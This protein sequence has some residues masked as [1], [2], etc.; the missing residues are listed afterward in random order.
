[1]RTLLAWLLLICFALAA[2]AQSG[3][4]DYVMG[5]DDVLDITVRNHSE[6][7]KTV[8]ILLDGKIAFGEVGEFVAAGKTPRALAQEI[9]TELEKTRNKVMVTVSVKEVHSRRVRILGAVRTPGAYDLKRNW[10]LMDVVAVAGG[11]TAKPTRINGRI[12]HANN[13][14]QLVDAAAAVAK[15]D[16]DANPALEVD[17]LIMLDEQEVVK[18]TINILGQVGKPGTY[19]LTENTTLL[20]IIADANGVQPNAALS[21]AYVLRGTTRIPMNMSKILLKSEPDPTVTGFKLQP[22]DLI[23]I[24]E[25][26]QRIAI[27]GSVL[28]PGY[29]G[30]ADREKVTLMDALGIAGGQSADANMRGAFI[31]HP[32]DGTPPTPAN[33][34]DLLKKGKGREIVLKAGDVLYV[35]PRGTNRA[36]NVLDFINPFALL[37]NVFGR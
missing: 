20:T 5:A 21:K 17:D 11:L 36:L 9:Q 2:S 4:T 24:P 1:M 37:F 26:E 25:S 31:A 15:P 22:N 16:T 32:L 3:S 7:N 13:K 30:I 10:R 33:I 23:F 28:R 19:E 27:L 8:T 29:Y 35:P 6:L 34:E 12:I 18:Q 14:V